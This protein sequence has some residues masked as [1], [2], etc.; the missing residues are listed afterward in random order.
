MESKIGCDW[1][2]H[3]ALDYHRYG[4]VAGR[5]GS[6][7]RYMWNF[8]WI[9]LI[10]IESSIINYRSDSSNQTKKLLKKRSEIFNYDSGEKKVANGMD[11]NVAAE[12]SAF[13]KI[14]IKK[15][16]MSKNCLHPDAIRFKSPIAE[17][18]STNFRM[19]HKKNNPSQIIT[20]LRV[21]T[22]NQLTDTLL[23]K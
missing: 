21:Q 11:R 15:Q 17:L 9:R 23:K 2:V 14:C 12:N 5:C 1:I 10:L 16:S 18:G 3:P 13:P 19:R 4:I 7:A 22:C 8:L 6:G 20:I